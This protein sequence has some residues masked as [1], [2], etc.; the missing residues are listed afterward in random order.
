MTDLTGAMKAVA[1]A[2]SDPKIIMFFAAIDA[3]IVYVLL[4]INYTALT[5]LVTIIV[6]LSIC[7]DYFD[8]KNRGG[9]IN[10]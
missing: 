10:D 8:K 9:K 4:I 3:V 7:L 1:R 5:L 2:L 6:A